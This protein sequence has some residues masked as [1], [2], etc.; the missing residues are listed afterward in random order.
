MLNINGK[1]DSSYRY[2]MVPIS[3][4]INGKGNGIYTTFHNLDDV[5]K[6]ISHPSQLILKYLSIHM[7]SMANVEKMT[8][9]GGYK[10]EELQTALQLYINRFVI[11]PS[12][13]I[14]ETIPQLKKESKKNIKLEL[15]CLSCGKVSEVIYNNKLEEKTSD[16]IIKYLDKN[17]WIT[18]NKGIM[19]KSKEEENSEKEHSEKEDINPFL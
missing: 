6:Y 18:A 13:T 4:T 19:V 14:P 5:C 3:S 16:L 2:K 9:T 7:G 1:I 10:N 8:I 15:K 11:C 12:C 17:D